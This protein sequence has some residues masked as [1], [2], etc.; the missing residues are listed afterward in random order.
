MEVIARV[1][2][3]LVVGDPVDHE[4]LLALTLLDR[5][6]DLCQSCL[7]ARN[8]H[9]QGA[10]MDLV[11]RG[12]KQTNCPSLSPAAVHRANA[13]SAR[14]D[15]VK[16]QANQSTASGQAMETNQNVTEALSRL[17]IEDLHANG[18]AQ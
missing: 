14:D 13:S 17:Q 1:C 10:T 8:M 15:L 4:Q 3:H 6:I 9:T 11:S 2:G 16:F 12:P 5:P 18:P 7:E